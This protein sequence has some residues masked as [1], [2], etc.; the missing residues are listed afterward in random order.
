MANKNNIFILEPGGYGPYRHTIYLS[1][2]HIEDA[3]GEDDWMDAADEYFDE[4]CR[5][6]DYGCYYMDRAGAQKLFET[7]KKLLEE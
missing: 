7:L 6:G 1:A 2:D 3:G 4:N 5:D